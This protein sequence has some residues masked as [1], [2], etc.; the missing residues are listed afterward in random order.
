MNPQKAMLDLRDQ[1]YEKLRTLVIEIRS[2]KYYAEYESIRLLA[3]KAYSR[4][5]FFAKQKALQL[6]QSEKELIDKLESLE[7][8]SP[9]KFSFLIDQLH[10]YERE[11]EKANFTDKRIDNSQKAHKL[12]TPLK[13]L[14]ALLSLPVFVLGLLFNG[15]PFYVSRTFVKRKVKDK[16]FTSSF[17]LVL[18]LIIYP[19]F[20]LI[21]YFTLLLPRFSAPVSLILFIL[22][23]F[24]GKIS[25]RLLQFYK[26][27]IQETLYLVL[28]KTYKS[29][30][31]KLIEKRWILI[32]TILEK[33]NF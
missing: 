27:I 19:I 8:K 28:K 5:K 33:A 30:I 12:K 14:L 18:G 21:L 13:I 3:G 2:E 17:N 25:Y 29:A 20:Y 22:M 11:L 7:N 9:E 16:V 1:I 24:L 6:F 15:I 4:K 32:E 31:D 23:P 10:R 26:E